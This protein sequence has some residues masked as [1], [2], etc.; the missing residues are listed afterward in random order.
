MKAQQADIWEEENRMESLRQVADLCKKV[1]PLDL[2]IVQDG[3]SFTL[4]SDSKNL[5]RGIVSAFGKLNEKHILVKF[6]LYRGPGD[7]RISSAEFFNLLAKLGDRIRPTTPQKEVSGQSS[8]WVELKVQATPLSFSRTEALLA[9]LVDLQELAVIMQRQL[10]AYPTSAELVKIYT[11]VAGTLEPVH[12]WPDQTITED[13]VLAEWAGEICDY[14]SG[15]INVAI[16]APYPV[17]LEASLAKVAG[18]LN[19]Q[20]RTL[21][22]LILPNINAR[23]LIDINRK[24][25]GTMAVRAV[26]ISLGTSPYDMANDMS[27][28]TTSLSENGKP[29][30]FTGTHAELQAI[31]HGGQGAIVD[32]I[33]PIL[34]HAPNI[35]SETLVRFAVMSAGRQRNGIPEA[36][37]EE[38]VSLSLAALKSVPDAELAKIIPALA[39]KMVTMWVAGNKPN[40]K[41][42]T[43]FLAKTSAV[44]ETLS[45]LSSRP[46]IC[47]MAEIQEHFTRV[48][49]DS[50]LLESFRKELLAQDYALDQLCQ[51]LKTE[52]LTRPLHQ[53]LRYCAQSPPG[54]GKSQ[55]TM[56]LARVLDVPYINIDAA[57][58]SDHHT[59][60]LQL[61]GSGRGFVGSHQCGR[62]EHAAKHHT[63][64]VIEVSDLDH[65][66]PSVRASLADLFLQVLDTG[67]AQSSVGAMFSCANIIFVFT[68]N[69]PGG[70]DEKLHKGIGFASIRSRS[71]SDMKERVSEEIK[72]MLSSAFLSR[73]GTP[74]VFDPLN[75]E[76]LALIVERAV[77]DAAFTAAIRLQQNVSR[78]II[79]PGTGETVLKSFKSSMLSFGARVLIEHARSLAAQAVLAWIREKNRPKSGELF[80]AADHPGGLTVKQQERKE[81]DGEKYLSTT[82]Y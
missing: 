20:N 49:A 13:E 40:Q 46:R 54:T 35:R 82:K 9:E 43:S 14:L 23:R 74:I 27:A 59:A 34:C 42:I 71:R 51:R 75:G 48:L 38:L 52:C 10:P 73:V 36:V 16:A 2:K 3:S 80:I 63:G 31:F 53:P 15:S 57:S 69:L 18:V 68:M 72:S 37:I 76:A 22:S 32:P 1:V 5:Y 24:A 19:K 79:E 30:L 62:L 17:R 78:V 50:K 66:V 21:G 29:A 8:L 47:R 6:E 67:E 60:S 11:P 58:M 64:V 56:I 81:H 45:G 4:N 44:S 70:M 61:L 28:L 25:P 55:S 65:A 39:T 77:E 33:N 41:E 7:T 26:K 12:P